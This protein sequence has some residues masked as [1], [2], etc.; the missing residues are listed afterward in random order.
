MSPDRDRESSA[1]PAGRL[2]RRERA[3]ATRRRMVE[4]AYDL[5]AERGYNV[6]LA[7][8]AERAGVAV[9]TVYFTF[10]NKATLMSAVLTLAVLGDDLPLAP[11]Q[12]PW[13][14]RL[15]AEPDPRKA[16]RHMV[17][18][19]TDIFRRVAP[20]LGIFQTADPELSL[21]WERSEKLR[22]EGYRSPVMQTLATKGRLRRGLDLDAAAD[23][24]FVLLSPSVYREMVIQRSWAEDRWRKWIAELIA[25]ALFG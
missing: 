1:R 9:Q 15:K 3:Q 14:D 7:E 20:L 13:F 19:T 24:L 6:P 10:H 21:L 25:G 5:F 8:V 11:H 18:G 23:I 12:R 22:L 2:A 4:A 16:L 17:D